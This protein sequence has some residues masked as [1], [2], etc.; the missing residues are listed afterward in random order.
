MTK[1]LDPSKIAQLL[2]LSTRQLDENTL[3]ALS[4]ARQNALKKQVV[5]APVFALNTGRET[6][7]LIPDSVQQWVVAGLLVAML[8]V[9]MSFWHHVQEQQIDELD[10][11]ILTDDLPIEA[12]VD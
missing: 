10:V 5:R 4:S 6:H 11:A 2:T 12:F 9:G 7:S 3:S 1:N 8:I